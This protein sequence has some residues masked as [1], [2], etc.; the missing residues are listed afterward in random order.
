MGTQNHEKWRFYT[1]NIWVITPKNEGFTWVPMVHGSYGIDIS[2]HIYRWTSKF[3]RPPYPAPPQRQLPRL[4][5]SGSR[6]WFW[7]FKKTVQRWAPYDAC[8]CWWP[9]GRGETVGNVDIFRLGILYL[10]GGFNLFFYVHPYL[11][12]DDPIWRA[13]FSKGLVQPPTSL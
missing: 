7:W 12:V 10:A 1:P 2:W 4:P 13:Y 9:V 5:R 8:R 3:P 6:R 11:P